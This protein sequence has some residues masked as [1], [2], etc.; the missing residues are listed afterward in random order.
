MELK[1]KGR[2]FQGSYVQTVLECIVGLQKALEILDL[3]GGNI[4]LVSDGMEN[5]APFIA[6]VKGNVVDAGV[7]V[8]SIAITQAADNK[9]DGIARESGGKSEDKIIKVHDGSVSTTSGNDRFFISP[10]VSMDTRVISEY[11]GSPNVEFYLESS[12]GQQY[13]PGSAEYSCQK[14]SNICV[15]EFSS[16][17]TGSWTYFVRTTDGSS[18][19]ASVTVVGKNPST[20]IRAIEA[21]V[22]WHLSAIDDID[23][24]TETIQ[25][26][27][28]TVS[29]GY[30]PV[31]HVDVTVTVERPGNDGP[32]TLVL[33]DNGVGADIKKDDGIYSGFFSAFTAPGRY[34]SVV[35]VE[36]TSGSAIS[37]HSTLGID[38]ESSAA[39]ASGFQSSS[40]PD[41]PTG[42][43]QRSVSGQSFQLMAFTGQGQVIYSPA[44]ISDLTVKDFNNNDR[45]VTLTW[46][47]VGAELDTGTASQYEIRYA[48]DSTSLRS[49]FDQQRIVVQDTIVNGADQNKPKDAGQTEVFI[50]VL[51][52]GYLVYYLAVV[53]IDNNRSENASSPVSNV[54]PVHLEH[55]LVM[56]LEN[57]TETDWA[58]SMSNKTETGWIGSTSFIAS[59]TLALLVVV[60]FIS[61]VMY[62][63]IKI[64]SQHYDL[65][66]SDQQRRTQIHENVLSPQTSKST[67]PPK[68][69]NATHPPTPTSPAE[70]FTIQID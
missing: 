43:F 24:G 66:T 50:I 3:D 31:V 69:S 65:Q 2:I 40:A 6:E 9:I 18:A 15:F 47:A 14:K 10:D 26:I 62:F 51:P 33:L 4:I 52:E 61:V 25:T 7:K 21:E 35:S 54:V 56:T 39:S 30:L 34:G 29:Q 64:R 19:S 37:G 22:Y 17:K 68:V 23:V 45:S 5:E 48:N 59:M 42:E 11:Q 36:S 55:P 60:I 41:V 53:A 28:A 67:G 13:G 1:M 58:D 46:T 32:V 27:H 16:I 44:R 49:S 8:H 20:T 63:R 38:R 57:K 12:S 70:T